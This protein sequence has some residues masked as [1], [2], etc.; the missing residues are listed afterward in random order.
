MVNREAFH[1]LSNP[2]H[3]LDHFRL[4]ECIHSKL[5]VN[6]VHRLGRWCDVYTTSRLD[7]VMAKI[8]AKR[9][10]GV[11]AEVSKNSAQISE[12]IAVP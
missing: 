2:C 4:I 8:V 5:R 12:L 3:L 9:S 1:F 10:A 7:S 11:V 6:D